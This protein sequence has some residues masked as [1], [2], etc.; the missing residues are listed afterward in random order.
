MND[1]GQVTG[2]ST[3]AEGGDE[4]FLYSSGAMVGI[5]GSQG[6]SVNASGEVAGFLNLANGLAHAFRYSSPAFCMTSILITRIAIALASL[7][8]MR[9]TS[10][11]SEVRRPAE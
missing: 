7:S 8:M 11:A 1:S 3:N 6:N 10:P 4:A 2:R 5:G 9:G